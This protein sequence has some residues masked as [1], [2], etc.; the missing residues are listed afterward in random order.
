MPLVATTL[1]EKNKRINIDKRPDYIKNSI[2]FYYSIREEIQE[3][4]Q[5]FIFYK[6]KEK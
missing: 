2:F 3:K 5:N 1:Y 4:K 6:S